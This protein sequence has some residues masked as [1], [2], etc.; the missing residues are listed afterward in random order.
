MDS[1]VLVLDPQVLG[2]FERLSLALVDGKITSPA[3]AL[4]L[5]ITVA[6][7]RRLPGVMQKIPGHWI[8]VYALG[9]GLIEAWGQGTLEGWP[10]TAVL[11]RG[12]ITGIMAIGMWEAGGKQAL[13]PFFEKIAELGS[14]LWTK[15]VELLVRLRS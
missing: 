11:F 2:L 1:D 5:M 7:L 4:L 12:V 3:V 10:W 15:V 9:L 8:P 13:K 6:I 14:R